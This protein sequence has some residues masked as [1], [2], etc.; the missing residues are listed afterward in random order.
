VEDLPEPMKTKLKSE[1][2]NL[3]AESLKINRLLAIADIVLVLCGLVVLSALYF[4]NR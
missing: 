2:E 3:K 4:S 1:A